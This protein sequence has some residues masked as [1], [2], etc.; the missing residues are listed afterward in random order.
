MIIRTQKYKLDKP[1]TLSEDIEITFITGERDFILSSGDEK[2]TARFV[3]RSREE[4]ED[5]DVQPKD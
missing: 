3:D 2:V 4:K 5:K 1:I